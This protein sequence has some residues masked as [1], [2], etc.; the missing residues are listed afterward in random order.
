MPEIDRDVARDHIRESI[1]IG[2]RLL[3]DEFIDLIATIAEVINDAYR[4]GNKV[5]L[6]GNGGSAADA[7]HLAAEFV[8]KYLCDRKALP[9][10]A[11]TVNGSSLTAIGND[12]GFDRVFARQLEA[13]GVAGDIVLGISTSGKSRNVIA[14]LQTAKAQ[15][16][17]TVGFTG[18]DGGRIKEI[19]D[20]FLC[21]PSEHTPAI[22]Q[23]HMVIGHA[24]CALVERKLVGLT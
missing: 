16:M 15:G 9:A 11:L 17:I 3:G 23:A 22:Q 5:I 10:V 7:Q 8:G 2:E 4:K 12:F 21:V 13:V 19:V 24:V 20:Y 14:A 18:G 1:R 6:F